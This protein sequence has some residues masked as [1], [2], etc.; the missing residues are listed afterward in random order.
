M[1]NYTVR[2]TKPKQNRKSDAL[3]KERRTYDVILYDDDKEVATKVVPSVTTILDA[4]G[5]DKTQRLIGWAKREM[6][7]NIQ[8][9]F[10]K[11]DIESEVKKLQDE[12][13]KEDNPPVAK[14][15]LQQM[16]MM[17]TA[18][19]GRSAMEKESRRILDYGTR[20]HE[21]LK[22]LLTGNEEV[23][24]PDDLARVVQA[25]QAWLQDEGII[26]IAIEVPVF[27]YPLCDTDPLGSDAKRVHQSI[28][29]AGTI[30]GVGLT[31]DRE[32]VVWD[33][34]TGGLYAEGHMQLAAY[35]ASLHSIKQVLPNLL[36][37]FN[38]DKLPVKAY[39]VQIPRE[40]S[41]GMDPWR[42][43]VVERE[44]L[45]YLGDVFSSLLPV[46][47]WQHEGREAE[48]AEKERAKADTV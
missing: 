17:R 35:A 30:D 26:P 34:K 4:M 27:N 23:D 20:A 25:G 2:T 7:N 44:E 46:Y 41:E 43:E 22:E 32:L 18:E 6:F 48:K 15:L 28:A 8:G 11:L 42:V 40:Y 36:P 1:F 24:I 14:S 3:Y 37:D 5:G 33:W 29:Y 19:E 10:A 38:W 31:Q 16:V 12:V 9:K 13:K 39:L 47:Q 21:V 45:D